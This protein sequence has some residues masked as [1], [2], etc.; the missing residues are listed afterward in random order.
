MIEIQ[1]NGQSET[2]PAQTSVAAL[3]E[4]HGWAQRRVAVECN[5]QIVPK[6]QH[7]STQLQAGDR[8]EVVHAIGGG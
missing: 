2:V 8:L 3:L 5:G 4:T 1:L 6:S 7:G